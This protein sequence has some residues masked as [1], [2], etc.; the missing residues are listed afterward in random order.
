MKE[1]I[2]TERSTVAVATT[3]LRLS[4]A[5]ACRAAE[6]MVLPILRL[7]KP[8]HNFKRME[9]SST[10]IEIQLEETAS[11]ETIFSMEL[12]KSSRPISRMTS[13][14]MRPEM[15]S[16]RPCPK[17]CWS[18]AGRP[19]ILN[20]TTVTMDEPASER[21]LKASAVMAIEFES[22]PA[23]NLNTNS[24][25]LQKIPTSPLS[26]PYFWRTFGL[27]TCSLFLIKILMSHFVML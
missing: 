4:I 17:G 16:M 19:A 23:R 1:K 21:L 5:V 26:I 11:G 12:R 25:I 3:S 9:K 8:I 6:R 7:K 18:S 2:I 14:T 15:Y 22:V 13:E 24:T 20:P 10:A 27:S